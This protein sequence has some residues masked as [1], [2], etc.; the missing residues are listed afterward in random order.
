MPIKTEYPAPGYAAWVKVYEPDYEYKEGGEFQVDLF[1]EEADAKPII[2]LYEQ[3]IKDK[4]KEKDGKGKLSP[5]VMYELVSEIKQEQLDKLAA[6]GYTP[7]PKMYRFKFRNTHEVKPKG[8]T[9]FTNTVR[10]L[11]KANAKRPHNPEEE[12]GN[13][14]KVRVAYQ[15]YGWA[16]SGKIGCKLRL[17]G[18]Q[19]LDNSQPYSKTSAAIAFPGGSEPDLDF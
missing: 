8:G 19:V 13:G 6:R 7:D 4:F 14:A 2:K 15:P 11:D 12:I 18:L 9:P 5:D 17:V 10:V 3:T 16:F 1:L